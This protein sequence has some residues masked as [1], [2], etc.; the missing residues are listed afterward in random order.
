MMSMLGNYLADLSALWTPQYALPMGGGEHD[1]TQP[2]TAR[3]CENAGADTGERPVERMN[4]ALEV[5]H[6][7][8][9][10]TAPGLHP[11]KPIEFNCIMDEFLGP[12]E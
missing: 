2:G 3:S 9:H 10:G 7:V 5:P 4:P 12:L 6:K 8:A 11:D 1:G